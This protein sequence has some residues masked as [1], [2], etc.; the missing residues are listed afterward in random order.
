M[1]DD[2][3]HIHISLHSTALMKKCWVE[4]TALLAA[5]LK[6][7]IDTGLTYFPLIDFLR[8][9]EYTFIIIYLIQNTGT[10]IHLVVYSSAI[11]A[12]FI[13]PFFR[14]FLFVHVGIEY[15]FR[16]ID[17]HEKTHP[18]YP[19]YRAVYSGEGSLIGSVLASSLP[20]TLTRPYCPRRK[21]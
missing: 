8:E 9:L 1:R 17:I 3:R 10:I 19:T 11:E 16:G 7:A 18:T 14:K 21:E 15:R 4:T 20:W 6:A 12:A 13:L 5:T 2:P